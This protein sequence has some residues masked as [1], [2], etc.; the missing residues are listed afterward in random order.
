MRI[1]EHIYQGFFGLKKKQDAGKYYHERIDKLK[2]VDKELDEVIEEFQKV[3]ANHN[4]K[5]RSY[6]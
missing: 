4:N 5:I 3:L 1:Q 2:G 6:Y